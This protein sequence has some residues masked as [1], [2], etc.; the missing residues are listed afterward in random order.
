MNTITCRQYE[1]RRKKNI[2]ETRKAIE[3]SGNNTQCDMNDYVGVK[4][5][6][7]NCAVAVY[8]LAYQS[9]SGASFA[10]IVSPQEK[11]F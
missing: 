6:D 2:G 10:P 9:Q 3:R 4:V 1:G 8:T 11:C 7:M 5:T